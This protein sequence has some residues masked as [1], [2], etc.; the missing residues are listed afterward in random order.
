MSTLDLNFG[1]K[2]VEDKI[3]ASQSYRDLKG[4]YDETVKKAGDTFEQK[5][6]D[7]TQQINKFKETKN[8]AQRQV[9][10]QFDK[11]L[12]L[13][14]TSSGSGSATT[15]YIKNTLL[16]ALKNIEPKIIELLLQ[17]SISA[18]GCD[19]QQDYPAQ[20][21]YI[22]VSSIDLGGLLKKDPESDIGKVLYE[23]NQIAYQPYPFAMNK[24]LYKR[25]QSSNS[26]SVDNGQ[27][28]F[29]Y[30]SQPL[31]DIQYVEL[32]NLGET[33]P[34]FKVS[35][36]SRVNNV[37]KV[38]VF[39][40]DY[41][42]T[43]KLVDFSNVIANIMESLSGCVSI[44]ANVGLVQSSD[45]TKF[46]LIL[47]RVLGLCFDTGGNEIDV[48][49]I[50]KVGQLDNVDESF[51]EFTEMDLRFIEQ[52]FDNIKKGV[53]QFEDCGNVDLPVDAASILDSLNQLNFVSDGNEIQAA[54][55]VTDTLANNPN[56]PGLGF[57]FDFKATV[58]FN[59]IKLIVEGLIFTLL[60]PKILLPIMT[61]YKAIGQSAADAID[62]YEKF[63]KQF[64]K[65]IIN[66]ISKIG[67][68]FVQELFEIIK[69]D[70][71]VLIQQIIT[72]LAKEKANKKIIMILKL[73]QILLIIAQLISDWRR[74]KSV[75][76]EL[77]ALLNIATVGWG[78]EVPLPLLFGAQLLDG[79]SETRAFIGTIEELQKL[80]IPTGA[81]PDGGP[82][83]NVLSKF[84][85]MKAQANEDAES[86]KVQIAVPPLSI[87]PAGLTV[88]QSAFGKKF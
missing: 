69:K 39:L 21:I 82:N 34:W 40:V 49:G 79:Y 8:R 20:D 11:L 24:E 35:L 53:I 19:Q 63:A 23:K 25:I 86:G 54:N 2:Q 74:C 30:S 31:F 73:I 27:L 10:N 5:K 15:R 64:K 12:N 22:K 83:L 77:L 9:Q 67:A 13:T 33:G 41:Y 75:I 65:Y 78:G 68:L 72:D 80:G 6:S 43:I 42:K 56:W 81:M 57:N 48:S 32:N 61:M 18:I 50:A 26:Y 58:D 55:N 38:G 1:Y 37:Q 52:R 88:P 76:D 28:Y 51:F 59:F 71:V 60:S 70:I 87:T 84:A 47:Q 7:V 4:Q 62:S 45:A 14:K 36:Q 44:Q 46:M 85:Q 17:E 3:K 16:K 29:G 66:L